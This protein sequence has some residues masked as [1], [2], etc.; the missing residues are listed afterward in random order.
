MKTAHLFYALASAILPLCAAAG[1]NAAESQSSDFTIKGTAQPVCLMPE[2]QPGTLTNTTVAG[3]TATIGNL[4]NQ[5]DAKIN[6]WSVTFNFEQVM[7]NYNSTVSIRS[8]KG[9][10]MPVGAQDAAV[11]GSG[12]FLSR[13]DYTVVANWGAVQIQPLNAAGGSPVAVQAQPGGANLAN[14]TM[15]ISAPA[16]T[17]PLIKGDYQDTIRINVGLLM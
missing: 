7:C 2:P 4:V 10:M 17:K 8:D 16:S 13:V 14:L 9:G 1:V 5:T 11:S 3:R 12:E 6:P 15:I